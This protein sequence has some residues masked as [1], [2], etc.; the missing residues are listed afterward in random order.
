LSE[1]PKENVR[2]TPIE[3]KILE[4]RI[5]SDGNI[6]DSED[7]GEELLLKTSAIHGVKIPDSVGFSEILSGEIENM[8]LE[9]DFSILSYEEVLLAIRI[10]ANSSFQFP[11]SLDVEKVKFYGNFVSPEFISKILLN[12]MTARNELDKKLKN[13]I[14]GF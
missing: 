3:L 9:G 5:G 2:L 14:D 11:H 1:L 7:F 8:I 10:N 12:Y 4:A 13:F 6:A